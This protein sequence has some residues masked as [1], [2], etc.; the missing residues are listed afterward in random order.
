MTT[1]TALAAATFI[2]CGNIVLMISFTHFVLMVQV[3]T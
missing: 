2:V 1:D 3:M